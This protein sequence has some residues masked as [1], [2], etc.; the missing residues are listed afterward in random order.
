MLTRREIIEK[1]LIRVCENV[2]KHIVNREGWDKNDDCF[3]IDLKKS[4]DE[5]EL[6]LGVISPS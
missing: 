3:Q 1:A 6:S 4:V 5:I 2:A